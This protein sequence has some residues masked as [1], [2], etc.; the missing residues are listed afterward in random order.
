MKYAPASRGP[1]NDETLLRLR[2]DCNHVFVNVKAELLNN[3][4]A[5]HSS[6]CRLGDKKMFV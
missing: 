6:F 2:S 4:A 1:H 5:F 3:P